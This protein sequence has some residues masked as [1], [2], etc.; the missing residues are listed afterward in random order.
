MSDD[1]RGDDFELPDDEAL[2]AAFESFLQGGESFDPA[3]FLATAGL[4]L[5]APEIK[6]M[7]SQLQAA[8]SGGLNPDPNASRDHAVSVAKEGALALDP[9]TSAALATAANV[10]SLWLNEVTSIAELP[11][12]PLIGTRVE[13]ARKT[14][15]VWEEIVAPVAAAIPRAVSD[16][17]KTG[18]PE[19]LAE[20]L[21]QVA[22]PMEKVSRSLFTMQLSSVVG[23]LATE[24]LSGGDIG[25]PLIHGDSEY[26]V[27]AMLIAQNMRE[28]SSDL[29][30]PLEEA[31]I[32]LAAREIA[33]AR[34]F[35]HAK[36]LRLHLMSTIHD[37]AAGIH[38]DSDRIM[39]LSE[40]FDPSN[41]EAMK[42][43][44]TSGKL[45]PERTPEQE[46]AL[47][48]LGSML[49]LIEGWVDHVTS[50]ATARLP[51][52][53]ALGEAIRRR[54]ASGGPAE[55]AFSTLVGLELRPRRLREASAL[56]ARIS[57]ALGAQAR[58][59]LWQHPDTLPTEF[60]IDHPQECI[61]RLL[62]PAAEPDDMDQALS[63]LLDE[64]TPS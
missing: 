13:W 28:F 10:A 59:A 37:F 9:A 18:A 30:I 23:K 42:D 33:H 60:D 5:E 50:E 40:E 35:R 17:M 4:N 16:M 52:S 20:A 56:W 25:I 8:F 45:L 55:R 46:R 39:E 38:I 7:M 49:A 1:E 34:L 41:P 36:W 14:L 54:R 15:P 29:D 6:T 27:H 43:L 21:S 2:R 62:A 61:E 12:T 31:D 24:V 58:D 11:H 53:D 64:E 19:E 57:E 3:Q 63:D 51:K 26:D 47:E 44:V 48:R 32:F 22:A